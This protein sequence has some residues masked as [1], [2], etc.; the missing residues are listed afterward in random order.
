[1]PGM[2]VFGIHEFNNK[3]SNMK[4]LTITTT[5]ELPDDEWERA[6]VVAQCKPLIGVIA[7]WLVSA[8]GVK[9]TLEHSFDGRKARGAKASSGDQEAGSQPESNPLYLHSVSAPADGAAKAE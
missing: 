3:E 7:E 5:V 8:K 2:L 1:M 9:S 4:T 6:E